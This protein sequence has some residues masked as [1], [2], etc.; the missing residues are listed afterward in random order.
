LKFLIK[1]SV[2]N[3][4]TKP[5]SFYLMYS[6]SELWGKEIKILIELKPKFDNILDNKIFIKNV[7][8]P[9]IKYLQ[10]K[11]VFFYIIKQN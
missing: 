6:T 11:N 1:D 8:K 10:K 9:I 2:L 7:I 5:K 4:S 3:F